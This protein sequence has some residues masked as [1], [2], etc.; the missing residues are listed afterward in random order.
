MC[1]EIMAS[2]TLAAGS[3]ENSC[4]TTLTLWPRSVRI[5]AAVSNAGRITLAQLGEPAEELR[6]LPHLCSRASTTRRCSS[7]W[8]SSLASS[9]RR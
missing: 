8:L 3:T 6:I 5:A 9:S 2:V 4:S 7:Y 1:S